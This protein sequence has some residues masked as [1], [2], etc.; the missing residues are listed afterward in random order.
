MIRAILSMLVCLSALALGGSARTEEPSP[1]IQ[2]ELDQ[3]LNIDN[4]FEAQNSDDYRE[5]INVAQ[6][7]NRALN[8][9]IKHAEGNLGRL[10]EKNKKLA[11]KV[12]I[13]TQNIEKGQKRLTESNAEVT[14]VNTAVNMQKTQV[15]QLQSHVHLLGQKNLE[16]SKRNIQLRKE[17]LRLKQVA[18]QLKAKKQNLQ[19]RLTESHKLERK[20]LASR[21]EL[22]RKIQK[23]QPI[24]HR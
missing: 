11:E 12:K 2:Q 14:K 9:E 19:K 6:K 4:Q 22:H 5:Q 24:A 20:L 10:K 1:E 23:L 15:V 18:A 7:D 17:I 21:I 13:L 3:E 16:A 8:R